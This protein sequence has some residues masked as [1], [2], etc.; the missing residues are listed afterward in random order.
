MTTSRSRESHLVEVVD[1]TGRPIGATTV[2]ASH[3][4]PGQLH[5]AFSVLLLDDRGDLLLQRRAASKTRFALRWANTCCGHPGPG[6]DIATAASARL[7]EEMGMSAWPLAEAG[8][9][10]YHAQDPDSGRVEREYD[11]V[12][13]ARV[14]SSAEPSPDPAEVAEWR[15]V[16]LDDLRADLAAH[17]E[18]YAPW[19]HDVVRLATG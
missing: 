11:H 5:R 10:V 15:W 4:A 7:N 17:P 12:L 19:L 1:D 8:R 16:N 13:T 6:E 9:F 18:R 3:A 14:D 2:A